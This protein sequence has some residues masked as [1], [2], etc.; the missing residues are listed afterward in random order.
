MK[1]ERD[2]QPRRIDDYSYSNI[3]TDTLPIAALSA[4][5]YGRVLDR[6]VLKEDVSNG[7][8]RIGLQPMDTFKLGLVPP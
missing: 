4:M 3:N 5:Q 7:F 1:E 2:Q 8:Y 6:H